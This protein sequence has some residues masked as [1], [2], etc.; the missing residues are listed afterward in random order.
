MLD[1]KALKKIFESVYSAKRLKRVEQEGEKL[2]EAKMKQ[3]S[4][5]KKVLRRS[6]SSHKDLFA[7][8]NNFVS[9]T[10]NL[11][12]SKLYKHKLLP[13]QILSTSKNV[14]KRLT[15]K[16]YI[17]PKQEEFPLNLTYNESKKLGFKPK[18]GLTPLFKEEKTAE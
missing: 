10:S 18:T 3:A 6:K 2:I 11:N 9:V 8:M 14:I 17:L 4:P 7:P 13:S 15:R 1:A 16:V 5:I 12:V